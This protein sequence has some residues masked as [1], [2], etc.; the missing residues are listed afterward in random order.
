MNMLNF[1]VKIFKE[2]YKKKCWLVEEVKRREIEKWKD[3]GILKTLSRLVSHACL[4]M[5]NNI[6][7][8]I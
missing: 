1:F 5:L 4:A 8:H 3:K 7:K 6:G 2:K